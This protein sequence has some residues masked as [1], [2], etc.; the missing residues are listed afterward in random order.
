[1]SAGRRARDDR[2]E[3]LVELAISVMVMSIAVVALVG[4]LV[5]AVMM[6]DIHRKQ[7]KAGAFV[8]AFSEAIETAVHGSPSAYVN[9]ATPASYAGTYPSPD[10]A[11]T[12]QIVTIV[13]WSG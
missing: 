10:A 11:F 3:T 4:G 9:C 2:G 7:A 5:T 6:S 12:T 8:R 1:M 13:Y